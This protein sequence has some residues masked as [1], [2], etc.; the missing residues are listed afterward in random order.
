ME[1]VKQ[2]SQFYIGSLCHQ[3]RNL[4]YSLRT[5][6]TFYTKVPYLDWQNALQTASKHRMA[7]LD[8][9]NITDCWFFDL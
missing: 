6:N 5:L 7:Q 2:E 1:L 8:S 3:L 4:N 9:F